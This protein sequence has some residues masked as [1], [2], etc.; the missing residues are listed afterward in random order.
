MVSTAAM[1]IILSGF[2]G[3]EGLVMEMFNSFDSDIEIRAEK[4]KTFDRTF[5]P[6][7]LYESAGLINYT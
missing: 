7:A 6:P 2:N 4:S 5:I 3:I 1:V